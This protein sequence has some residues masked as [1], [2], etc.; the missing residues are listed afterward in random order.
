MAFGGAK[1]GGAGGIFDGSRAKFDQKGSPFA[2]SQGNL[3]GVA[4]SPGHWVRIDGG[5]RAFVPAPLPRGIALP[6][7]LVQK[8]GTA[9]TLL[10]RLSEGIRALPSPELFLR[11]F[12]TRE[13][14]LSSR[15]EGTRTTLEDALVQEATSSTEELV[16]DDREV[17]NYGQALRAGVGALGQG[18]PLSVYLLKDLHRELLQGTRGQDK[19]PGEFQDKQVW[20]GPPGS[21]RDVDLARFVPPP[22][23]EV[24][25][26]L[27]DL[28]AYLEARG[29][30]EG[31]VRVALAHYQLE[32]I[33]PFFDGNGRIGRLM[34]ALQLV[35]EGVL[36]RTCLFVS[37]ALEQRRHEY[38]DG[39]LRVSAEGDHL[40]WID[41]F[42]DVVA[43]SATETL[44]RLQRLRA[45]REEFAERLRKV[46]SQ[47]PAMLVQELFGRP[48]LTVPL[49]KAVLKVE[50]AT[51]Q[52]AIHKLVEV[53]ILVLSEDRQVLRRGRPPKLY[54][55]PALLDILRE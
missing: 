39:L 9:R 36:D 29:P 6:V 2:R 10:G 27:R 1:T 19:K 13:A 17:H 11:P 40:G 5:G 52:Q 35:W 15:I 37:P 42:V 22:A 20:I 3:L 54:R 46:Q 24:E 53:G 21:E 12:Q 51:A 18:R 43:A 41:F 30:D 25:P 31:L 33:H 48:Y 47:K 4:S 16:D 26:A 49:A 32:T 8:I 38:Y 55:C 45:L 44:D 28:D 7:P 34:I 14:V 23:L 50:S